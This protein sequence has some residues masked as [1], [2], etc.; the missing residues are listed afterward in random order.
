MEW[1]LTK[2]EIPKHILKYF[3]P[4]KIPAKSFVG[5]PERFMFMM[6]DLGFIVRS[7]IIWHKNNPMPSSIKD[8]FTPSYE[9][10]YFFSKNRK[11]W[12]DLDAVREE[13][14]PESLKRVKG[15]WNGH[16]EPMSSYQG[17]DI[18]RMCSPSGKNPGDVMSYDTK[19]TRE[20]G[21]SLQGFIRTQSITK[22]RQQ[23]KIDAKVLFPNDKNQQQEYI[24]FIHDHAGHPAGPN[25]GDFWNINTQPFPDAHFACVSEDTECLTINGWK[26]YTKVQRGEKIATYSLENQIIEYQPVWYV[27]NYD[28]DG[29]L[30]HVGNRDLDIL[31]TSDHRN[32]V[33]KRTTTR[34]EEGRQSYRKEVV[35]KADALAYS[36]KIRVRAEVIYP[37]GIGNANGGI[38]KPLASLIGW[39]ISEGNYK[40]DGGIEISQNTGKY[41]REIDLLLKRL[42][43]P[44]SKRIRRENQV[45]WYMMKK[46]A[47]L[48]RYICPNKELTKELISLP[49][50]EAEELFKSLIKGDGCER[51]DDGRESFIQKSKECIDWF[52]ILALR[53]GYHCIIS[54]RKDKDVYTAFLTKRTHIGIRKTNSKG[55]SIINESYK[56]KIWCPRVKNGTWVAR[57]NGRIFITGNTFPEKLCEKP[58]LAGCP[59]EVCKHCGMARVR[60][61]EGKNI[62]QIISEKNKARDKRGQAV[63][64]KTTLGGKFEYHTIGWTDCSCSE[65]DKYEPGVILDPFGGSG[66]VLLMAEKLNRN[67]I[68]IDIKKEYCEMSYKRL[69]K[70]ITQTE[71]DFSQSK[72]EKIGF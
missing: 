72:I 23:S 26:E 53:L 69:N 66:T 51:K 8:S 6:M 67:S 2:E 36:D 33:S 7:K 43:I 24:N 61:T 17:M 30:V 41:E 60:I 5:I 68:I 1:R 35:V 42:D 71:L 31:M 32:V 9:M 38:G 29:K 28:F 44:H 37:K 40:K 54:K 59:A 11:Y 49:D 22:G 15:N 45:E 10:V 48:I 19:Y 50:R 18:K 34:K 39:I 56:G 63:S 27:K 70:L 25:P 58:I 20:H 12:F 52:S 65:K 4:I 16:R 47:D 3:E 21:Q 55:K 13:H 46:Y 14:K 57:R 64:D 62:Q